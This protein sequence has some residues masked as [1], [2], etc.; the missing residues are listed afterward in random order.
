MCRYLTKTY[1]CGHKLRTTS[2][3]SSIC[4]GMGPKVH[5][6]GSEF[7]YRKFEKEEKLCPTCVE[8][9]ADRRVSL[10]QALGI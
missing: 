2:P 5:S 10:R 4:I 1:G 9:E 7:S 3:T 6:S 8:F